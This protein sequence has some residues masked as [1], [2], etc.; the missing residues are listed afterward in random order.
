MALSV[1]QMARITALVQSPMSDFERW[2]KVSGLDESDRAEAME[3]W[4]EMEQAFVS[5]PDGQTLYV[6]GEWS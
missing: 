3:Y 2:F 4:D 5:L 1:E 6:P